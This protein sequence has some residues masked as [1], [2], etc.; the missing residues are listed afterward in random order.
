MKQEDIEYW[1]DKSQTLRKSIIL[2]KQVNTV[3]SPIMYI[4]KPKHITNKDFLE[5]FNKMEIYLKIRK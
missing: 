2:Y 5:T 1:F 3:A 4:S